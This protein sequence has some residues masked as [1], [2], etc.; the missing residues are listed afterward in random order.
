MRLHW[1][2]L[3]FCFRRVLTWQ[4]AHRLMVFLSVWFVSTTLTA[5]SYLADLTYCMAGQP[6]T[7]NSQPA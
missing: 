5:I 4:A 2:L 3:T 6:F 7:P 1:V